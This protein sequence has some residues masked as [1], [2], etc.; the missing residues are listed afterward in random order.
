MRLLY[1]PGSRE[2]SM[3]TPSNT[4]TTLQYQ[5]SKSNNSCEIYV[6]QTAIKY[7]TYL[8]LNKRKLDNKQTLIP[9]P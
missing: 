9:P 4:S 1:L 2:P 3:N 5:Y 6:N 7:F 8:I